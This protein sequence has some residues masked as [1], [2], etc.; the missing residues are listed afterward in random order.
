M[1]THRRMPTLVNR[2]NMAP[3]NYVLLGVP[4]T[5]SDEELRAAAK[6]RRV[7]VHPDR[8]LGDAAALTLAQAVN[9]AADVLCD[10]RQRRLYD[11]ANGIGADESRPPAPAVQTA[12]RPG[13]A[14]A[15]PAPRRPPLFYGD[16]GRDPPPARDRGRPGPPLESGDRGWSGPS[17]E[18]APR[19][20]FG[21]AFG[22]VALSAEEARYFFGGGLNACG[23]GRGLRRAGATM[24]IP[25]S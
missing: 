19:L 2:A 21:T 23:S 17:T 10:P 3:D 18:A 7:E 8:H 25:T 13:T 12:S 24:P 6:R 11:V 4:P 1:R 14:A 5:A 22:T 16:R 20:L 15:R 9:A